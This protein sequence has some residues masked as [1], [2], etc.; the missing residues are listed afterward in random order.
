MPI[1]CSSIRTTGVSSRVVPVMNASCAVAE[2][3]GAERRF[4]HPH[5][6]VAPDLEQERARE[7]LEQS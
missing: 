7:A 1:T 5:A 4:F 2:I 3:L 6:D